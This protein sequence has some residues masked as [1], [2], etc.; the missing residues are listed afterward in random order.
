MKSVRVEMHNPRTSHRLSTGFDIEGEASSV[1][2]A[3]LLVEALGTMVGVNVHWFWH[4]FPPPSFPSAGLP[5]PTASGARSDDTKD[6][7]GSSEPGG[8]R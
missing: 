2:K 4:D 3:L 7:G 8:D 5:P 6:A 1:Y